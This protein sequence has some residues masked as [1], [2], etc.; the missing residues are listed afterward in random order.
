MKAHA[1]GAEGEPGR[2]CRASCCA[3]SASPIRPIS[4]SAYPHELSGGMCQRIVIA[5]ALAELA[6]APDGRRAD[7]GP[8]RDDPDPDPR[9]VPRASSARPAPRASSP[10]ATWPRSRTTATGSS[11]CAAAR[12]SSRP[13][14]RTFFAAPQTSTA[15]ICCEAA[16]AAR[17][18]ESELAAPT[19]APLPAARGRPGGPAAAGGRRARQA[20]RHAS[21]TPSTRSTASRSRSSPAGRSALVG[22]SGSG[23]TTVGRCIA[24]LIQPTSGSISCSAARWAT[25]RARARSGRSSRRTSSSRSPGRA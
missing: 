16:I 22:E 3:R 2:A 24:G 4:C 18:E 12:S 1:E 17:G 8:R 15:G 10:R 13:R 11:C 19:R 9:P 20:L 6:A 7:G 23:K 14:S 5:L 21:G 25:P